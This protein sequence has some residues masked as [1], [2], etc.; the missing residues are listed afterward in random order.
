MGTQ[1]SARRT[2]PPLTQA[3]LA[4]GF[5]KLATRRWRLKEALPFTHQIQAVPS[6]AAPFL[7]RQLTTGGE[8]ERE[9]AAALLSQLQGPRVIAPLRTLVHDPSAP[10]AV[11]GAA[12]AVLTDLGEPLHQQTL[13]AGLRDPLAFLEA[14]SEA[15]LVR[16]A[17]ESFREQFL[18]S[19]EE[20]TREDRLEVLRSL[21]AT[22]D[23]RALRLFIPLL[24]SKRA[25][26]V[27]AAIDAIEAIGSPDAVPAL[28]ERA[29][30]ASSPRVRNRARVAQGRL[31][32][33]SN[34]LWE[35]LRP[36]ATLESASGG[37]QAL[38]LHRC[39]L[40]LVDQNGDQA[41]LVSR[42]RP[43]GFL[44][45][46]TVHI[47]DTQG[48]RSCY[49]I[50]MMS[51]GELGEL[52]DALAR[53]GLASVDVELPYCRQ[54]VAEARKLSV[55]QRQR[56]PMELEVWRGVIESPG[57]GE[58]EQL[59]LWQCDS[60]RADDLLPQTGALLSTPEFRQWYFDAGLVWPYVDEW[61]SASFEDQQGER[62]QRTLDSLISVAARDL[63]SEG[64]RQ[65]LAR[66]LAR[67]SWLLDRMG[68]KEAARLAVAATQGLDPERGVPIDLHPFVRAMVLSSFLNAGLRPPTPTGGSFRG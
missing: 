39:C 62:G 64:Q 31:L 40:T 65:L 16:G 49:G 30:G 32:M 47:S 37:P 67:Q 10:D 9:V 25:G 34:P 19:V 63:V 2:T 12:A 14:V 27:L 57:A 61:C 28:E 68:K 51:E 1:H 48:V 3:E 38:P 4:D 55:A 21:A 66:R 50:D 6:L 42:R 60:V 11:R 7:V 17:E 41:V 20:D 5:A 53:Q 22:R 43:D 33:R 24:F 54:A 35:E 13:A 23:A 46:V 45:V 56:L 26:T 44:K 36:P 8:R 18:A 59:P 15:I 29:R 58:P 52:T